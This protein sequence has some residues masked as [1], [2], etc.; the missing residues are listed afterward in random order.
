MLDRLWGGRK[1]QAT[2]SDETLSA[3][4]SSPMGD[5]PVVNS[6]PAPEQKLYST[7]GEIGLMTLSDPKDANVECASKL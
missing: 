3:N 5:T 1:S 4:N 7:D 6:V 2:T